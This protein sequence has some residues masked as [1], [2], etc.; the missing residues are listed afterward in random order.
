MDDMSIKLQD[1]RFVFAVCGARKHID[2]LHRAIARLQKHTDLP[3]WVVTDSSRNEVPIAHKPI[4]D[5]QAPR[6]LDHHQA[7]IFLKTRLHRLLPPDGL[8]C[9]LDT[10]II[11]LS[12]ECNSVFNAY[13]APITF[14]KDIAVVQTFS[15]FAVNC[16]CRERVSA[17]LQE[18]QKASDLYT[19]T[20]G[21]E[22]ASIQRQIDRLTAQNKTSMAGRL[23]A[24]LRYHFSGK[25]YRLGLGLLLD[26]H[27]DQWCDEHGEPF[28]QRYARIPFIERATGLR[29]DERSKDFVLENGKSIS[30]YGCC[31]LQEQMQ[32]A[33]GITRIPDDWPLWNGGVF[34]FDE[35]S[36]AFLDHWHTTSIGIFGNDVWATRDQATLV[37]AVWHFA[38]QLHPTLPNRFNRIV[39]LADQQVEL[40]PHDS[41]CIDGRQEHPALLHALGLSQHA[42]SGL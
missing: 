18:L 24:W 12:S 14:A 28:S 5:H 33:F 17:A 32:A 41:V 1:R 2:L 3:I 23:S 34:L 6:E 37:A 22:H 16:R 10:D 11:A 27:S 15:R 38:L 29:W 20:L 30:A 19:S 36:H 21:K 31:C 7:S 35:R 42:M 13:R 39:D 9:Y 25:Y 8:Y 40:G 4:L 26:K